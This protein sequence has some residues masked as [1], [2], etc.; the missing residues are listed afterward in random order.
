MQSD[1]PESDWK[2]LS[3]LKPLALERLCQRILTEAGGILDH[4]QAGGHH[5][6][7]LDLYKHINESDK[8]VSDCFDKW[9]RSHALTALINWRSEGLLTEEEFGV[10]SP[11]T[12]AA[13]DFW[14]KRG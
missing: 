4:T 3:R 8:V 12:R 14:L 13:V 5:R 7:Y 1:F 9:S 2:I 11:E 6:A 10:F